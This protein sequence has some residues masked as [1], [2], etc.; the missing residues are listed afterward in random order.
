ML[1]RK[2][3]KN[4]FYLEAYKNIC[5]LYSERYRNVFD[6]KLVSV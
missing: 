3:S 2:N 6:V 5:A 4:V 1:K